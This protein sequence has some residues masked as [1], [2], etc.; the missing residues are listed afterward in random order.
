M[1]IYKPQ[2]ALFEICIDSGWDEEGAD[3]LYDSIIPQF[4]VSLWPEIFF[5]Y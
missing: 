3:D 2:N 5:Y 1:F 4:G